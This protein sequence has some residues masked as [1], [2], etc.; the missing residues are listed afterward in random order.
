[1]DEAIQLFSR[2]GFS[3]KR[4]KARDIS[5][6][7]SFRQHWPV[8]CPQT[9]KIVTWVKPS[10][11]ENRLKRKSHFRLLNGAKEIN[12]QT[13]IQKD[14]AERAKIV[15]ETPEHKAAKALLLNELKKRL[16]CRESLIWS[17][18]D[19]Y[20]SDYPL[21]GDL[22]LCATKA[23]P[24]FTIKTNFGYDFRLDIALKAPSLSGQDQIIVGG[25]EIENKHT[26]D[27]RKTILCKSLAFPLI[28][29]DISGMTLNQ[30]NEEWARKILTLST[31]D[32]EK[33]RRK[34]YIYIHDL[35]FP[36]H[37]QI[38][39]FILKDDRH[40]YLVFAKDADYQRLQALVKKLKTHLKEK[41]DCVNAFI[42]NAKSEQAR[43]MLENVGQIVGTDW[44]DFNKERCLRITLKRPDSI[45]DSQS[46]LLHTIIARALLSYTDSL[47]GYMYRNGEL[48]DNP[49]EDNWLIPVWPPKGREYIYY[50]GLPK[51]LSTPIS[52]ILKKLADLNTSSQQNL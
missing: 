1:M 3:K 8:I 45:N 52:H 4:I 48:N 21:K 29:V 34:T 33:R 19:K 7:E 49:A 41:H 35:L 42:I 43:K 14:D 6:R 23:L 50:R 44:K 15:S 16:A 9:N 40:Q 22:L 31:K 10:F 30:I 12:V 32:D 5:S 28:S 37:C 36:I 51:R 39:P 17:F 26:F 11:E 38:P 2:Q 13:F 25:I 24:E 46:I 47:V 20:I 27:G 18:K